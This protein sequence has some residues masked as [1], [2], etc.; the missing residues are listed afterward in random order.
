MTDKLLRK[1]QAREG[2]GIS[3]PTLD[4]M[5]RRGDLAVVRVSERA[6]RIAESELRRFVERRTERRGQ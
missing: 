3:R 1:E 4:R 5:I 6:V 2:L